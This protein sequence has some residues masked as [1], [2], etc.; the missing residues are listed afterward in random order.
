[1][2]DL[3]MPLL[4]GLMIGLAAV[5]L[6]ASI[7]RIMGVSGIVSRLLPPVSDDW[8]WRLAFIVG[9]LAVP[10]LMPLFSGREV[11]AVFTASLPVMIAG[12]FLVGIGTRIGSGCTSGHGVCGLSRL[13]LRSLA[14][15]IVFM[16]A[17]AATVYV[18]RHI[19]GAGA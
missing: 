18:V 11:E 9:L 3:I 19:V 12:G 5:L 14:A 6:M 7:G 16:L 10:L 2:N 17:A 8:P 15:V 4:G 1:M 13:S